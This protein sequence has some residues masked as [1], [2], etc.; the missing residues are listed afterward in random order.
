MSFR[1]TAQLFLALLALTGCSAGT[2]VQSSTPVPT[3]SAAPTLAP[4]PAATATAP[5][6]TAAP[7]PV[8]ATAAPQTIL[9]AA[10]DQTAGLQ[11]YQMQFTMVVTGTQPSG[12][13]E[14]NIL[15]DV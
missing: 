6:A 10:L 13:A 3:Q 2:S 7:P 9:R 8:T 12:Q 11:V 4:R 1:S 15:I 14:T 5:P